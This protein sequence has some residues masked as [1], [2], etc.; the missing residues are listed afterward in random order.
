MN[1]MSARLNTEYEYWQKKQTG[2][3]FAVKLRGGQPQRFCGPLTVR[4]YK[5][6]DGRLLRLKLSFRRRSLQLSD[7]RR[8]TRIAHR[9]PTRNHRLGT[10][11][12]GLVPVLSYTRPEV[13]GNLLE[14][15]A[16]K[17]GEL[18]GLMDQRLGRANDLR[19]SQ[20]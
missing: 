7:L 16:T 11:T 9:I 19:S 1:T 4:Q 8:L 2:E 12:T 14:R 5:A 15:L 20:L 18:C 10:G 6:H 17:S 13:P 3:V